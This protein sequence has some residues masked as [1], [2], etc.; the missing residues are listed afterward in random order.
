MF[1]ELFAAAI[2][3]LCDGTC[4]GEKSNDNPVELLAEPEIQQ[5]ACSGKCSIGT[6]GGGNQDDNRFLNEVGKETAQDADDCCNHSMSFYIGVSEGKKQKIVGNRKGHTCTE[7]ETADCLEMMCKQSEYQC[8]NQNDG[9]FDDCGSTKERTDTVSADCTES[10][11]KEK[12]PYGKHTVSGKTV[13]EG[14][15]DSDN[16][17][18]C[19]DK[20]LLAGLCNQ[21]AQRIN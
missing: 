7:Q 5:T 21:C 11:A 8:G 4:G 18:H 2:E 13:G 10:C 3:K 19:D 12:K 16:A 20:F 14:N 1:D 6:A 9:S 15:D 17:D